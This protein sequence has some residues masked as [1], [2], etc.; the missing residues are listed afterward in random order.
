[1]S[2]PRIQLPGGLSCAALGFGTMGLGG[3]FERDDRDDADSIKLIHRAIDLGI[4][5]FDTADVYGAGH[6]EEVLGAAVRG[7]RMKVPSRC[8]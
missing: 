4:N 5:L 6:S 8:L 2:M 7:R 1:M 3:K